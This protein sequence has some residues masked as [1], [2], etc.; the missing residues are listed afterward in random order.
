MT[1]E[2][3]SAGNTKDPLRHRAFFR[4]AGQLPEGTQESNAMM[5]GL[6]VMRLLDKW[7][8]PKSDI[9]VWAARASDFEP[10]EAHIAG[11]VDKPIARALTAIVEAIKEYSRGNFDHRVPRLISYAQFLEESEYWE[12]AAD[13]Y[14]T[15]VEQIT[16]SGRDT[17][18][19]L[20]CY[21][22]SAHCL[23]KVGQLVRAHER[24]SAGID[25]ATNWKE[26]ATAAHRDYWLP[27]MRVD[28]ATVS[29]EILEQSREWESAAEIYIGAIELI[30][31][32]PP[33]KPQM[34]PCYERAAFCLRQIG[35]IER[36]ESLLDAGFAL[37][38]ELQDVHWSLYLRISSAV[39]ERQ[40]GNLGDAEIELDTIIEDAEHA[41]ETEMIARAMHEKGVV[42]YERKQVVT[43]VEL[44]YAAAQRY[45]DQ[46]M[47][48]RALVD[49]A[50][51]LA[52]LGRVDYARRVC[53][54]VRRAPDD[55][56]ESRSLAGVNLMKYAALSD[57]RNAFEHLRSELE[58]ESMSGR[59][60]AHYYS[61]MGQGLLHFGDTR[62]ARTAFQ[63][64]ISIAQ[65]HR[66]YKLII[67][68]EKMLAAADDRPVIWKESD[69][70]PGLVALFQDIDA[71]RGLFAE[72][73][74]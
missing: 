26:E 31:T 35:Q 74:A 11:L 32:R 61:F 45:T 50:V 34:L 54:V 37:A 27:R 14:D 30:K 38:L 20:M 57:D 52:D 56:L 25:V 42:A 13:V 39:V 8:E 72:A 41:N 59:L 36:A 53:Q 4:A 66:V 46:K 6:V 7:P 60:R 12:A 70:S 40:K 33:D 18:L 69:Q 22:R 48:R 3:A 71:A 44:V 29:A 9:E 65:Q 55:G 24:L 63:R 58:A 64:A 73:T 16:K 19:L 28:M 10:V 2:Q 23:R 68:T 67:D 17:E 21:A 47:A 5:A 62:A 51:G 49:A 15:A 43:A 1:D